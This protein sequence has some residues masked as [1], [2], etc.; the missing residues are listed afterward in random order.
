MCLIHFTY[1]TIS[2]PWFIRVKQR[3]YAF[4][5]ETCIYINFVCVYVQSLLTDC[6]VL[7]LLT[8]VFRSNSTVCRTFSIQCFVH[9]AHHFVPFEN[10]MNVQHIR[11]AD[12]QHKLNHVFILLFGC[13][14]FGNGFGCF[15]SVFLFAVFI[16]TH[17]FQMC[18]YCL[19]LFAFEQI[20]LLPKH[21]FCCEL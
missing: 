2:I 9:C 19:K 11:R 20:L 16:F 8:L 17:T 1:D 14:L 7:A 4:G 15:Y 13:C 10:S 21:T 3:Q 18:V 6:N 12:N 5:A